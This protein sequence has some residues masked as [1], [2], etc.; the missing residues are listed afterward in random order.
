[1]TDDRFE[2]AILKL[3]VRELEEQIYMI[4]THVGNAA[5]RMLILLDGE[6]VDALREE[7]SAFNR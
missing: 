4:R 3:R 1:M 6:E 7:I 5:E 2:S